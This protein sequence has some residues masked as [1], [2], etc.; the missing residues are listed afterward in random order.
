MKSCEKQIC[1]TLYLHTW[2]FTNIVT[3]QTHGRIHLS[4]PFEVGLYDLK[5]FIEHK[6]K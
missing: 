2:L 5:W 6:Q 1:H 3:F 4:H